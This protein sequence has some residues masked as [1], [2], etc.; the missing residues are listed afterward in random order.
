MKLDAGK[1]FAVFPILSDIINEKRVLPMKGAYRIARMA[2]KL[3][4]EYQLIAAKRDSIITDYN[5]LATPPGGGP[6]VPTVPDHMTEDFQ[7]KVR[8]LLDTEIDVD[9]EPI[10]LSQ[11]DLGPDR[12]AEISAGE[13]VVLGDLIVDDAPEAKAA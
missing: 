9:I 12:P 7:A 5:Y 8:E 1:V 10:L 6:A 13:L 2:A 4:P 11:L 3:Q